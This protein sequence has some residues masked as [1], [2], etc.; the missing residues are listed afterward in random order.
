MGY[1]T[2]VTYLRPSKGSMNASI[3]GE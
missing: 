1:K 2:S 3:G